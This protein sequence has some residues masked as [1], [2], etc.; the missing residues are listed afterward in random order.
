[1][2][3]PERVAIERHA[4]RGLA[5]SHEHQR[6]RPGI[7]QRHGNRLV[8]FE[9]LLDDVLAAIFQR[10]AFDQPGIHDQQITSRMTLERFDGLANHLGQRRLGVGRRRV[11]ER[12]GVG[13]EEAEQFEAAIGFHRLQIGRRVEDGV[14][15]NAHLAREIARVAPLPTGGGREEIAGAATE[16]NVQPG[17]LDELDGKRVPVAAV[18]RVSVKRGRGGIGQTAGGH[19]AGGAAALTGEFEQRRVFRAVG[20]D[21]QSTMVDLFA[22]G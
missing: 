11:M 8:E 21:G 14:F 3:F 20:I 5:A 2:I 9:D 13:A 22:A 16:D 4:T 12:K 17:T 7:L 15:V 6:L 18:S 1:M 10:G 19:E